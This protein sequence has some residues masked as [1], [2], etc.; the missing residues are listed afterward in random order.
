[1]TDKEIELLEKMLE[2]IDEIASKVDIESYF[3]QQDIANKISQCG[4]LLFEVKKSREQ[5]STDK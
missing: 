5:S 1:M 2:A 3:D 4:Q